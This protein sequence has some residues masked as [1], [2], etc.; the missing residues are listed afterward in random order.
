VEAQ[1][2]ELAI[3]AQGNAIEDD[4]V[5]LSINV[6]SNG[7]IN[8]S[9]AAVNDAIDQ[10]ME[11]LAPYQS[12]TAGVVLTYGH[13][14]S[15]GTGQELAQAVIEI[16]R[17]E[18]PDIFGDAALTDLAFVGEPYGQVDFEIYVRR[19]CVPGG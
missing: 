14:S 4:A 3:M 1:S 12:C 2:T 9:N 5:E 19:G 10:I 8:G 18:F 13:A 17:D 15:I 16:L 7:V 6:S 11:A